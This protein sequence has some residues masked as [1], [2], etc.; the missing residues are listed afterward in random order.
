ME[1]LFDLN[2]N[3]TK[4]NERQ[5]QDS[6]EGF[7]FERD[8][9]LSIALGLKQATGSCGVSFVV[10]GRVYFLK[11]YIYPHRTEGY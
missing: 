8:K 7:G 5:A 1:M 6:H 2:I 9:G 10:L 11:Y 3:F 4:D